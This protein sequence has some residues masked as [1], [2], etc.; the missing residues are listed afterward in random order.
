MSE[1]NPPLCDATIHTP[2]R[3]E[4]PTDGID[5][6][7]MKRAVCWDAAG[8]EVGFSLVRISPCLSLTRGASITP[9]CAEVRQRTRSTLVRVH[10]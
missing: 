8:N 5:P 3:S 10:R 4:L 6:P 7:H 9:D 1:P 2:R